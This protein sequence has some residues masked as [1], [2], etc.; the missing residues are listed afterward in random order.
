MDVIAGSI[1]ILTKD[2]FLNI[3]TKEQNVIYIINARD[4]NTPKIKNVLLTN[5]N[6][7]D[8]GIFSNDTRIYDKNI[9]NSLIIEE[10]RIKIDLP[11]SVK[12]KLR[13]ELKNRLFSKIESQTYDISLE[14]NQMN[15]YQKDG[16][17]IEHMD[18]IKKNINGVKN[19]KII[20]LSNGLHLKIKHY[21]Q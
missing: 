20:I 2:I 16:H 13:R 19:Q 4:I 15:I 6:K 12:L 8:Y 5:S 1:D 14:P 18:K 21:I 9:R 11:V 3:S 17:F 7:A 10:D